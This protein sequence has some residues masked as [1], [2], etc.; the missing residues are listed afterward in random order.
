MVGTVAWVCRDE[1]MW[2]GRG[3]KEKDKSKEAVAA[4]MEEGIEAIGEC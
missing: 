3:W 2:P 4:R 1:G